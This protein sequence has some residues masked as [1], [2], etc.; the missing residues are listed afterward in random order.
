MHDNRIDLIRP[1]APELAAHGELPVGVRTIELVHRDQIDIVNVEEGK[2]PPRYD[3]RLT[4]EVWYPA[5]RGTK[6]GGTYAGVFLRDGHT[7]VSLR[8]RA[9]RD[10][11]PRV[12]EGPFPLVI[13]SHGY[14]GN[15][16]LLSHLAE[17]LASKG[18][19]VASIDHRD[20]TYDDHAAF[21][22]TLVNR[23]RDQHFALREM[24]RL[25]CDP[26]SFLSGIIDA[27]RTA[28]VGYSMGG[29]GAIISAGA[30]LA[31]AATAF[32]WS[33]PAGTLAVNVAGSATHAA[34][35]DPRVKA[36]IAFAPWGMQRG[37]WDAAGLAGITKPL[38][39]VGGSVDDVSDYENGIARIFEGAV[40]ADRYLLTFEGANHNAAA[41]MPAPVESWRRV[42]N[43]DFVP[44]DHYADPVW[45]TVRMNNIAQHF[46]TAFLGKT[47]KGDASMDAYLDLVERAGDGV[48]AV[49][50]DGTPRPEHNYWKGFAPRTALGLSLRH[51]RPI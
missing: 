19:V 37:L 46:A 47:V 7:R 28:I 5:A 45:D 34:L 11:S 21:G 15:R 17:N 30:G 18:Y 2:P 16:F 4:V 9:A 38:M 1:D 13:V 3:R 33:P 51:A 8:G 23:P 20:S 48:H 40:N 12:G 41:P 44:F 14:P 26:A 31:E 39:V 24:D 50:D 10:A 36:V 6:P 49:S 22:S 42:S 32:D 29:Y 43:L 25:G 27:S 35:I